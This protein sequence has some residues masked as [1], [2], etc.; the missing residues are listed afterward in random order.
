M[1]KESVENK[2]LLSLSGVCFI[3]YLYI[4]KFL[5]LV[6][7]TRMTRKYRGR[8]VTENEIEKSRKTLLVIVICHWAINALI[9]N[10]C[11]GE[12]PAGNWVMVSSPGDFYKAISCFISQKKRRV[13]C[14]GFSE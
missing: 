1:T 13:F 7:M 4:F 8:S 12:R 11:P 3:Y 9:I 5:F 6:F 14:R 2:G 10:Q